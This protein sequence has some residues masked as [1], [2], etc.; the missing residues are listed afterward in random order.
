MRQVHS[1]ATAGRAPLVAVAVALLALGCGRRDEWEARAE[2]T[3]EAA[4]GRLSAVQASLD[5]LQSATSA[6][7]ETL[8]TEWADEVASLEER[9]WEIE[10]ELE[11]ARRAGGERWR[12]A[13][14]RLEMELA[15]L[16]KRVAALRDHLED[17]F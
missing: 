14:R 11:A 17:P 9:R 8:R 2:A 13:S 1:A 5:T 3:A 15:Q 10:A 4:R 6:R 12:E 7:I 16:E